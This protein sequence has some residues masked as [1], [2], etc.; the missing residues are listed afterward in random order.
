MKKL[1]LSLSFLIFASLFVFSTAQTEKKIVIKKK[2]VDSNGNETVEEIILTGE[3]AENVDIND[4]INENSD[5]TEIDIDVNI[6]KIIE[7][8]ENTEGMRIFQFDGDDLNEI[9]Q[10]NSEIPND[11]K[12]KLKDL[13][14]GNLEDINISKDGERRIIIM[15]DGE[16]VLEEDL[17]E[18]FDGFEWNNS[19]TF[20]FCD[21][22]KGSKAFLGVWPGESNDDKGVVL[23][24]VVEESAAEKAGLLEGDIITTIGGK[25]VKSFS[26]LAA[27]IK[28]YEPKDEIIIQYIRNGESRSANVMLG[29]NKSQKSVS[30]LYDNNEKHNYLS[31]SNSLNKK[32]PCCSPLKEVEKAYIGIMIENSDDD[33]AVRIVSVNREDEVLMADDIITKFGKTEI[34][35]I[36]ELI[37]AVS[38]YNPGDKVK[39][40]FLRNGES[41]KSKVTLLGRIVKE[42]CTDPSCC[43]DKKAT[44]KTEIT[45]KQQQKEVK[46][47]LGNSLLEL[48]DVSLFPNPTEGSFQLK[49]TSQDLSSINISITD[50]TGK[51]IINDEIADF[52]GTYSG[53]FNLKGNTPGLYLVNITQGGKVLTEKVIIK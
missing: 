4:Y 44:T 45:I 39:V 23:G 48:Q 42:C 20:S 1:F 40:Q 7:D 22:N 36:N 9:I 18:M 37:D 28:E 29:E 8:G 31:Y 46:S 15:S 27:T 6:E 12:I 38:E 25:T 3:D 30:Y 33:K 49:F 35:D 17:D 21:E 43:T 52:N 2:I 32:S 14:L 11:I 34:S 47:D 51:E 41:Q 19:Q 5:D 13:D 10:N 24:G 26:E 53:N 16:N 50:S